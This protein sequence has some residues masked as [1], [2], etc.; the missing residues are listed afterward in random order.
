M[1]V[2]AVVADVVCAQVCVASW[3]VLTLMA[4]P[5][6]FRYACRLPPSTGTF[7]TRS[8][9]DAV[10]EKVADATNPTSTTINGVAARF[11]EGVSRG[12]LVK[13]EGGCGA[14]CVAH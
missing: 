13:A 6:P 12:W 8:A 7:G 4:S 5:T 11:I 14:R 10:E 9:A 1:S 2:N 3:S